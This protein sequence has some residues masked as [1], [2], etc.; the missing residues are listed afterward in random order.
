MQ[1][2]CRAL[3]EDRFDDAEAAMPEIVPI[4]QRAVHRPVVPFA[5]LARARARRG[6]TEG[7]RTLLARVA[8]SPFAE[9]TQGRALLAE[10]VALACDAPARERLYAALLPHANRLAQPGGVPSMVLEE[11]I[12]RR[13]GLLAMA[14]SKCRT[15]SSMRPSDAVES[16]VISTSSS[17]SAWS[18]S[19]SANRPAKSAR[20]LRMRRF[21]HQWRV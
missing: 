9:F 2:L 4:A 17:A 7:A 3:V 5:L 18:V 13:L 11:P 20:M 8:G 14:A 21:S 15:A 1:R 6:D 19:T 12:A 10:A 16:P